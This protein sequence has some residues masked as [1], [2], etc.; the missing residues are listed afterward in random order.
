MYMLTEYCPVWDISISTVAEAKVA[1]SIS[2]H[3]DMI[4]VKIIMHLDLK[5]IQSNGPKHKG[6]ARLCRR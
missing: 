3:K 5:E 1:R 6:L 4:L 2:F